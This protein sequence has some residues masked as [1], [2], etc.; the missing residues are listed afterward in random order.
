M[1]IELRPALD[2][3]FAYCRRLYF[4]E[5]R[6]IIQE[7]DLDRATQETGFRQQWN[8]TQV[9]I[10]VLDG[11]DVGWLQTVSKDDELFVAQLFVD[12]RF[13]RKGVG[14]EVM[15]RLISEAA[16]LN[17][18]VG[19]SV[20]RMNPARRLYERLGFRITHEDDRKFYMKR[21]ADF[22]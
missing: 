20:V 16:A 17:L 19:L 7:L 11:S 10:I 18:A 3:D 5:T 4:D 6:W 21:D 14:T 15:N 9:R 2:H 22:V 8:S 1:L 13:Q 12:S